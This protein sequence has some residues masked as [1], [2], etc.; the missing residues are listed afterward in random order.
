MLYV[1]QK[2]KEHSKVKSVTL[3]ASRNKMCF[4]WEQ[5]DCYS[6]T[7]GS[8]KVVLCRVCLH[9]LVVSFLRWAA[10]CYCNCFRADSQY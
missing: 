1:T 9:L 5:L 2:S 6:W 10:P 8:V 4:C 3:H 7:T